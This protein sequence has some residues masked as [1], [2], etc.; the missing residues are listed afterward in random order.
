VGGETGDAAIVRKLL[1]AG[2][3]P[4]LRTD[5]LRG[6]PAP[7]DMPAAIF[8]A[9]SGNAETIRV[10]L[11]AGVGIGRSKEPVNNLL[12]YYLRAGPFAKY[13]LENEAEKAKFL[14][15]FEDGFKSLLKAGADAKNSDVYGTSA[16]MIAAQLGYKGIVKILLDH[17]APVNARDGPGRTALIYSF[18]GYGDPKSPQ[19][20]IIERLLKAGAD[21]NIVSYRGSPNCETPLMVAAGYGRPEVIKLLVAHKA[22]IN[23]IC[24]NGASALTSAIRNRQIEVVRAVLD[25]GADATGENGHRALTDAR[26]AGVDDQIIKLLEAAGAK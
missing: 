5:D 25:A 3:D 21:P 14:G 4:N 23:F 7:K 24:D 22:N 1:K 15:E 18:Y 2:I 12:G 9:K 20:E 11:E 26:D 19:F 13:D 16:L 17:G 10:F 8:A 6:V